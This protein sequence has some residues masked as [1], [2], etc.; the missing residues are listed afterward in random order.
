LKLG[1]LSKYRE[2]KNDLKLGF[3]SKYREIKIICYQFHT[4]DSA[5]LACALCRTYLADDSIQCHP[6]KIRFN[7][8]CVIQFFLFFSF[9]QV[10]YVGLSHAYLTRI[11]AFVG[12]ISS[13]RFVVQCS[14]NKQN[15]PFPVP[16]CICIY[17]F[18]L[19][20][21]NLSVCSMK[22]KLL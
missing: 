12:H 7:A 18:V 10:L 6:I 5:R 19:K 8:F 16:V 14:A 3:L 21:S 11:S 1:F 4:L 9:G 20:L 22:K 2:I 17:V 15:H 13:S